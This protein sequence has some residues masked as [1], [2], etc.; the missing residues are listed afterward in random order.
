MI[1]CRLQQDKSV[2]MNNQ[3]KQ[4]ANMRQFIVIDPLCLNEDGKLVCKKPSGRHYQRA[5]FKQG[6]LDGVSCAYSLAI[7]FN[8]LNAFEAD[9]TFWNGNEHEKTTPEWKLIRSLN[10]PSL[11]PNGLNPD[12]II[13]IVKQKYSSQVT[14]DHTGKKARIPLKVKECIDA[15]NPVIIQISCSK[16]EV[17][18]IVA[19]GYAMDAEGELLYLLTLDSRKNLPIGHF[20]N[21]ILNLDRCITLKYGFQYITDVVE[22]VGLDDAIILKKR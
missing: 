18:W 3:S 14:I 7:V 22:M 12:D 11:H 9:D 10:N 19:V 21:G 15:N 5:H 16:N 13:R 8:I 4:C 20:W 1:F 17:Q 2:C 6:D